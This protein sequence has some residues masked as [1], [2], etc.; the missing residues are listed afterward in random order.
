MNVTWQW[1]SECEKSFVLL[2]ELLTCAPVFVYIRFCLNHSFI[3]ETNA[4]T[5]SLGAVLS[6]TQDDGTVHPI[7]YTSRSVDKHDR[8]YS[9]AHEDLNNKSART[10]E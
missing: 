3:L 7:A 8:N 1:L 4:S 9:T 6:Q 10:R 2:K 5:V